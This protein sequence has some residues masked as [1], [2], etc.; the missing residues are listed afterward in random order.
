MSART[1]CNCGHPKEHHQGPG[2]LGGS[3][4]LVCT[5]DGERSWRHPYTP[6]DCVWVTDLDGNNNRAKDSKGNN[7]EHCEICGVNKTLG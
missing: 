3:Q 7:W 1:L 2:R 5:E 4:C 6:H